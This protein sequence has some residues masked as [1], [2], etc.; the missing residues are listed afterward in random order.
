MAHAWSTAARDADLNAKLALIDAH[1]TIHATLEIID[2]GSV[3]LA[4]ITLAK[5]SFTEAAGAL[6]L[7]GTPVSTTDAAATGTAATARIKDGYG[8]IVLSGITVGA[9]SGEINLN[10]TSIT[11]HQTVTITSGTMTA[12]S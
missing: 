6:T 12:G 5:P 2:A 4:I 1:A 11:Q 7:A 3:V 10:S 9:G 8:T